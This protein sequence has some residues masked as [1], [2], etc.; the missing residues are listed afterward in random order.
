MIQ[1]W[2]I[3]II[4]VIL[5]WQWRITWTIHASR[6][7]TQFT[8]FIT[9]ACAHRWASSVR[10]PTFSS[11]TH[12]AE[13]MSGPGH[14]FT[15]H[16]CDSLQPVLLLLQ[17]TVQTFTL[18]RSWKPNATLLPDYFHHL[19]LRWMAHIS[20]SEGWCHVY[21]VF[22]L[23]GIKH[24]TF[25]YMTYHCWFQFIIYHL[26]VSQTCTKLNVLF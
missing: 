14:V 8:W 1:T 5:I 18:L 23:L 7:L 12:T 3:I 4:L 13:A 25:Q 20:V 26:S 10:M 22:L 16:G 11:E 19:Y 24:T 2:I 6:M 9:L 21:K 17:L 15:A